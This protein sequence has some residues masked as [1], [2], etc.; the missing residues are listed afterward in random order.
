[1]LEVAGQSRIERSVLIE[2]SHDRLIDNAAFVRSFA[3]AMA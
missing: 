2:T 1:M 3:D